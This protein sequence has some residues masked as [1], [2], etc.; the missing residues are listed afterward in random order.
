MYTLECLIADVWSVIRASGLNAYDRCRIARSTS[1]LHRLDPGPYFSP[2]WDAAVH[3][4]RTSR[5]GRVFLSSWLQE[6]L[7]PPSRVTHTLYWL[8]YTIAWMHDP[9]LDWLGNY[10]SVHDKCPGCVPGD[11]FHN[12]RCKAHEIT[13]NLSDPDVRCPWIICGSSCPRCEGRLNKRTLISATLA[14]LVGR[15]LLSDGTLQ[16]DLLTWMNAFPWHE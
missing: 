6:G 10:V 8:E 5:E 9:P 2:E 7:P 1:W 14:E 15:R 12:D 13:V 16:L 11:N 3:A 4:A